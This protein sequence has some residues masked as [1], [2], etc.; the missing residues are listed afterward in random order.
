[1]ADKILQL[2]RTG[3]SRWYTVYVISEIFE[4]F[5]FEQA[6]SAR[7]NKIMYPK[8][9]IVMLQ[10]KYVVQYGAHV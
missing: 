8:I 4:T 3:E 6:L 2:V 9:T 5:Y 10:F 1:M 7:H